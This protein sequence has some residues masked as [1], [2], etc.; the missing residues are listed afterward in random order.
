MLNPVR[1]KSTGLMDRFRGPLQGM[2]LIPA[3]RA[4]SGLRPREAISQTA[5]IL[6]RLGSLEVRLARSAAEVRRAQK[7]RYRVF[8]K[9]MCA[10][11]DAG[12]MLA[13]RDVDPFD[14]ICDH[15]IVLDHAS[16]GRTG[17]PAIVGTYRLLRQ[18]IAERSGGFYSA[19]EFD[20]TPLLARHRA[21]KFLEL[22]RSCVLPA[23][24]TK[25]TVELLWHG[26]WSYVLHHGFDAMLGCASLE[27]TDPRELALPLS[28]LHH[29]APAPEEW[30]VRALPHR[31]IEMNRI[32]LE[33]I[34]KKAAVHALPPLVKGYL[35]L[36]AFIGD[37]AVI[38]HQFGTIDVLA[39]LPVSA[40]SARYMHY[41]GPSAARH[42]A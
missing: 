35:R 39:V 33:H 10:V 34:D 4:Y 38:D 36:G 27:G 11:P 23:Y 41:F 24:R 29:F 19:G 30:R 12:K 8:Y 2:P 15:M 5:H 28:F 1:A 13:Q 14:T 21:Y 17:K 3:L 40:I 42:A 20:I 37:G 6:G 7:L 26:V 32:S 22:G 31:Y 25:R 9:E 18:Q 16:R